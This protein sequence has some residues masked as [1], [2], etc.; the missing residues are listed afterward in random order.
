M[1][2]RYSALL[3]AAKMTGSGEEISE[4]GSQILLKRCLSEIPD[5]TTRNKSNVR[6]IELNR[7]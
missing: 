4:T 5:V 2:R 3:P 1:R 6:L 7:I